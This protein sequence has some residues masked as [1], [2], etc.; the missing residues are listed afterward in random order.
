[1]EKIVLNKIEGAEEVL[2]KF[3]EKKFIVKTIACGG[4]YLE[5][6]I[7]ELYGTNNNCESFLIKS[8]GYSKAI[9]TMTENHRD[10]VA[11]YSNI[12]GCLVETI[13]PFEKGLKL[14]I[15][16]LNKIV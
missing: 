2:L 14:A 1:M 13:I 15:D 11:Y 10:R 9:F 6:R 16:Y 4:S 5:G 8:I 12:K 7:I 3:G